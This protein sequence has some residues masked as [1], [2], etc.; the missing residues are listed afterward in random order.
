M[1]GCRACRLCIRIDGG[2]G[3]EVQEKEKGG[4]EKGEKAYL[5][6]GMNGRGSGSG[7]VGKKRVLKVMNMVWG[8]M[9]SRPVQVTA[10]VEVGDGGWRTF[11]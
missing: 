8:E 6:P 7:R 5:K 2:S 10:E 3:H 4:G 11:L 1:S 9:P